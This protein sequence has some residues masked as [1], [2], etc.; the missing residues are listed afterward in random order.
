MCKIGVGQPIWRLSSSNGGGVNH[1]VSCLCKMGLTAG[2]LF[3][4][5]KRAWLESIK[6][7]KLKQ[8]NNKS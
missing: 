8:Q 6:R 3:A 7:K 2:S 1:F 5:K 4:E